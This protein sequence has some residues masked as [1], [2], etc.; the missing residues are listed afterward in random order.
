MP[1]QERQFALVAEPLRDSRGAL[2]HVLVSLTASDAE[3]AQ[4]LVPPFAD[5]PARDDR[6][7]LRDPAAIGLSRDRIEA[8]E[9][10]LSYT[11]EHL[12]AAVQ[13]HEAS[14]EELQATNEELVAAN[15][16]LQSTNEEL[17][18]V[19]EEMYTVNAEYQKKNVELQQLNDDMEH[20]LN[21]TDLATL[22]L[23]RDLCI[24]KF[25][26]RIA[27]IFR[28]IPQDIGRPLRTFTHDLAHET[29]MADIEKVLR[30]G[31]AIEAQTWDKRQR[32]F[33]LRILPY[34]AV[35]L[36]G[37]TAEEAIGRHATFLYPA[38]RKEEIDT[39]LRQCAKGTRSSVW[40]RRGFGRTGAWSM[41]P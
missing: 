30:E 4:A 1:G 12:Q 24:R 28:V 14:N 8:L 36:Y 11:K 18:S 13:E 3:S 23:D 27:E 17:H 35:R 5:I 41:C 38:G 15:E 16:E 26:P 22:F 29:L 10:E 19:N 21:G 7:A 25:T 31:V 2:T 32:C 33:F 6:D 34:R 40:K 39:I 20:L 37:Y 9:E